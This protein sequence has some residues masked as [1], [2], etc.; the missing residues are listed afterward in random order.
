M[1]VVRTVPHIV[2]AIICMTLVIMPVSIVRERSDT[3]S[4]IMMMVGPMVCRL[5]VMH[6]M[7][8]MRMH[9]RRLRPRTRMMDM[10]RMV[11]RS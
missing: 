8:V 4:V 10:G 3:V 11:S 5:A 9:S 7:S 2:V 6:E 1:S